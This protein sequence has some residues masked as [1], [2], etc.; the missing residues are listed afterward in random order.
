MACVGAAAPGV[1]GGGTPVTC[2][3]GGVWGGVAEQ[4]YLVC[5]TGDHSTPVEYGDHSFEPVPFTLAPASAV[6]ARL[7]RATGGGGGGGGDERAGAA[8]SHGKDSVERFDEVAA[9]Q[10]GLGRFQGGEALGI[11]KRYAELMARCAPGPAEAGPGPATHGAS[12]APSPHSAPVTA[13][14]PGNGGDAAA[15]TGG[16][17]E[18]VRAGGS[19]RV[20]SVD[21]SSVG[22]LGNGSPCS[23]AAS[24][25]AT[26]DRCVEGVRRGQPIAKRPRQDPP[27]KPSL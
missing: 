23:P 13:P 1:R 8:S 6:A 5:V 26:G 7:R 12:P 15:R 20:D 4:R 2:V 18:A 25:G 16:E 9:A 27:R 3:C 21:S 14:P 11:L 17:D 19:S 24:L 22:G 10:G